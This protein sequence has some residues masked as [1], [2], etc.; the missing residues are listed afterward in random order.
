MKVGVDVGRSGIKAWNGEVRLFSLP[1]VVRVPESPDWLEGS[2]LDRLVKED[3]LLYVESWRL[4]YHGEEWCIGERGERMGLLARHVM[5]VAK[6]DRATRLLVLLALTAMDCPMMVEVC[7]GLPLHGYEDQG[8][9]LQDL[10]RGEHRV[11]VRGRER[12]LILKGVVVPE[13][14]GLWLR[15]LSQDGVQVDPALMAVP[16]AVLD[17]GH[18][19]VQLGVFAGLR[20]YPNAYVSA[21]GMYE[22]WERA[23]IEEFEGPGQTLFESPQRAVFTAQL[24]RRG[25]L[26]LRGKTVT[27]ATLTPRLKAQAGR[28]WG[29]LGEE[30]RRALE[31]VP[32]ERVVAGGGGIAVFEDYVGSEFRGDVT[33][34]RDRFAQAEG[35]RLFLEHRGLLREYA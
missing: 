5:T 24:L 11:V 2:S 9:V 3:G 15:S 10:L 21:H 22:L 8:R 19:T 26:T 30:M 34:L 32:Y 31:Q 17:F 12:T 33:F 20:M 29:R 14:L 35:Y 4:G 28:L 6:A 25:H 7:A 18:R 13:G 23:L 27:M 16:T 1:H